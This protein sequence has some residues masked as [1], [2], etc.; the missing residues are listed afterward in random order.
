MERESLQDKPMLFP[1]PAMDSQSKK[2]V[3]IDPHL[4]EQDPMMP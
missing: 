2:T 4:L 3:I 1:L